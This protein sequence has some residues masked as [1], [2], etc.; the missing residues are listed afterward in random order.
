MISV[1]VYDRVREER[2]YISNMIRDIIARKCG[3]R[4]RVSVCAT[5]KELMETAGAVDTADF[6]CLDICEENGAGLAADFRRKY[7]NARILLIAEPHI[8]PDRYILP[9]IMASA[10]ILRPCGKETI[11]GRLEDFMQPVLDSFR[12]SS[13]GVFILETR[14]GVTKIPYSKIFYFESSRKK[15]FVRLKSEE[16]SY[17][18]TLDQLEGKLPGEFIRCHRS[19]IVNKE[20]I[21]RY[22]ASESLVTLD[23]STKIPVSRSYRNLIRDLVKRAW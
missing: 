13:G 18:C 10:L 12:E 7:P 9:S 22:S 17:Y 8:A 3:E 21:V 20:R 6:I 14:E 23:D 15:I 4:S 5:Q 1:I 11:R 19:F 2:G 16:Y